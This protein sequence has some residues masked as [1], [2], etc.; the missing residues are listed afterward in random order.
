MPMAEARRRSPE[1]IVVPPR[2]EAYARASAHFRRILEAFT[3]EVEPISIDEAFLDVTGSERLFGPPVAIGRALKARVKEELGLC[4]SV[5]G[6]QV[7]FVAKIAT[8]LGKPDGLIIVPSDQTEH[9]LEPLP[10]ERLY[11]VGEKTAAELGAL[12]ITTIGQLAR[13]PAGVLERRLGTLG[14]LLVARARGED[15]RPVDPDREAASIG[16]EDTFEHDLSAG[17]ALRRRVIAQAER[18][19]ERLRREGLVART[20]VLKLKLSRASAPGAR[21]SQAAANYKLTTTRRTLLAPSCDGRVIVPVAT[22]LLDGVDIGTRGVRLSGVAV[23]GLQPSG[24]PGQL[25]LDGRTDRSERLAHTLDAIRDRLS[26]KVIR[27]ELLG[28][29]TKR[30]D[31]E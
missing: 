29:L 26:T 14:D 17:P 18:V 12:G 6:A 27:A 30:D 7:K 24:A 16:S 20:V 28:D 10:I 4:V 5:G 25:E 11:G 15:P 2:G 22:E 13:Y 31:S 1:A 9:F 3:P 21:I 23:T 19:A 8:E